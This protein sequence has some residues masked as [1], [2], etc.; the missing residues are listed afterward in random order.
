MWPKSLPSYHRKKGVKLD[1]VIVKNCI[2]VYNSF[3]TK[4]SLGYI[5]FLE[6]G[7]L[8]QGANIAL[9]HSNELITLLTAQ[10]LMF[11]IKQTLHH[12]HLYIID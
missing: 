1:L 11:F 2:G 6:F 9:G 3:T 5:L 10:D 4:N 7:E 12:T 8:A